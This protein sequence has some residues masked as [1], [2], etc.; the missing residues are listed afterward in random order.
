MITVTIDKQYQ[1]WEATSKDGDYRPVLEHVWIDPARY[2]I[3]A[4]GFILAVVPCIIEGVLPGGV[5]V[6]AAAVKA[7]KGNP[8][9]IDLEA[10]TAS[11]SGNPFVLW[12]G[13]FPNWRELIPARVRKG[14]PCPIFNSRFLVSLCR[15]IHLVVDQCY[16]FPTG[17][18]T[19][20]VVLGN[21]GAIG[22]LMPRYFGIDYKPDYDSINSRLATIR[23]PLLRVAD[24]HQKTK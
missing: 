10:Q 8:I 21:G 3:A 15:A 24:S 4:N 14:T 5:L 19:P 1:L 16:P 2:A 7:A 11:V 20:I 9:T 23:A 12:Q 6:P 22:V 18:Y 13:T 17:K